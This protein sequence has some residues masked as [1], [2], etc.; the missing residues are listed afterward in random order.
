MWS[1]AYNSEL[2]VL[3]QVYR[4]DWGA[5]VCRAVGELEREG[6]AVCVSGLI[7]DFDMVDSRALRSSRWLFQS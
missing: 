5:V 3:G 6:G 1:T 4:A 2:N 7:D